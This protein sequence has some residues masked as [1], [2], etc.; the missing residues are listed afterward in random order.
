MFRFGLVEHN[1]RGGNSNDIELKGFTDQVQEPLRLSSPIPNSISPTTTRPDHPTN[2]RT[3]S[4]IQ[5]EEQWY[6]FAGEMGI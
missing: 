3:R 5:R 4:G 2:S 1:G 6:T